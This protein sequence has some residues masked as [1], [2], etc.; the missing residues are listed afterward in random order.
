MHSLDP[1]FLWRGARLLG[2]FLSGGISHANVQITNRCNMRCGFCT[3]PQ[4]A[5]RPDDELTLDDWRRVAATLAEAGS[6]VVSIEGGEPLL[7]DDAPDIVAAFAEA[8]HPWLYTNGWYVTPPL[9][10]RLW[11]AG[12]LEVGVSIDYAT[13]ARHDASRH[14]PGAF[15]RAVDAVRTLAATSPRGPTRVHILSILFEDNLAELEPLLEL[16]G[17]LGVKHMLTFLSTTGIYRS[18]AAQQAPREP[19]S[20]R[21][22]ALKRRYPHLAIFRSYVDGIDRFLAG[23]VPPCGAGLTGMNIDHRGAVSPCIELA[24]LEAANIARE[25]WSEVRTKLAALPEPR[26]CKRCWTLC[27]GATEAMAGRPRLR[28]WKDFFSEFVQ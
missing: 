10:H 18:G 27:R 6:V 17:S 22:H 2:T 8:H 26:S 25:P 16:S 21:I 19:V 20:A 4:R 11:D 23:E 3:F 5:V 14:T 9:A 1:R 28:D 15:A 7:R 12:V 24:H 13:A